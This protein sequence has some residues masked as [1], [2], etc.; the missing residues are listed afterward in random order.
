MASSQL[1]ADAGLPSFA[2]RGA[3]DVSASVSHDYDSTGA[4]EIGDTQIAIDREDLQV[5]FDWATNRVDVVFPAAPEGKHWAKDGVEM[6]PGQYYNY[7]TKV[8]VDGIAGTADCLV[9]TV[10]SEG[11]F[12]A[13]LS[14]VLLARN[15][16]ITM[17]NELF[18]DLTG[19]TLESN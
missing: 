14:S 10:N 11:K 7:G 1:F 17:W 12:F 15:L 3:T 9:L 4:T 16:H 19:I 5:E 18:L 8:Y 2:L 13:Q 6:V